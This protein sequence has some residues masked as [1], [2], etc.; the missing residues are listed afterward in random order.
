MHTQPQ[1][2][3]A[4]ARRSGFTLIEL[5]VVIAIIAVLIGLLLPAVQ[6][7]RQAASR[8]QCQNN[9]KQIGLGI[10]NYCDVH[11]GRFPSSSHSGVLAKSWIFTLAPYLENVS[12]IR[13]CPADPKWQERLQN[14]GTSYSMNEYICESYPPGAINYLQHLPAT[15]RT[16]LVFTLS[17]DKGT[18]ATEDH[19]HSS[20]WFKN[21]PTD[22]AVARWRRICSDI[23][24]DR[25]GGRFGEPAER[26]LSG[27]SNYLFGDGHVEAIP[28]TQIKT[29]SDS[30][31]NF[32]IP[33]R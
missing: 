14:N 29:W 19:T 15:T 2:T 1:D 9:L 28:A 11:Q 21:T 30:N 31:E 16:I 7:V 23:Q 24:P 12:K 26:R 18:S 27:V 32:A 6:K 17:D 3:S 25:F 13:I 8:A 22:T 20:N 33:Q 4:L 5:L 10:H